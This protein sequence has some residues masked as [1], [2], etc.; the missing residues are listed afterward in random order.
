MTKLEIINSALIE[1]GQHTIDNLEANNPS[2]MA[3]KYQYDIVLGKMLASHIWRFATKR[4]TLINLSEDN[5]EFEYR[6]KYGLPIDVVRIVG[7]YGHEFNGIYPFNT[8][9]S[10][11][12]P[13]DF[14]EYYSRGSVEYEQEKNYLLVNVDKPKLIYIAMPDS[15][16]RSDPIFVRAFVLELAA[17]ISYALTSKV[18]MRDRLKRDA[19][20]AF[21]EARMKDSSEHLKITRVESSFERASYEGYPRRPL[22]R[23][24]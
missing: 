13:I 24:R 2:A 15:L 17:S 6:Y 3:V 18:Q 23:K 19:E 16:Q 20:L 10:G 21:R 8:L 22:T 9:R 11:I 1:V 7:V 14:F 4:R 5:P 12:A